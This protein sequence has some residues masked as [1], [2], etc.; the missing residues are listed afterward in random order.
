M[1]LETCFAPE[2]HLTFVLAQLRAAGHSVIRAPREADE[3]LVALERKGKTTG[4]ITTD[5]DILVRGGTLLLWEPGA[6]HVLEVTAAGCAQE[7]GVQED[8]VSVCGV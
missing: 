4:T 5:S 6:A 2:F 7:L 1:R 3:L 8:Q